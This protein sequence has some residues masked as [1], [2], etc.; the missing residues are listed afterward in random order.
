MARQVRFHETGGPEVLRIDE[1]EVRDPGPGEVRL[2]Q[3][4][5]GVNF[6]DIYSRSGLYPASLP[7]APG[8]E[9][10]GVVEAIGPGV[11]GWAEGDRA[12]YAALSGSYATHRLASAA[13]LIKLPD[14]V[15]D[16]TAAAVTLRGL[17]A[18]FLLHAVHPVRAGDVILLHAAAGGV[19]LILSQWAKALGAEVIGTVSTEAKA[20]IA[21]A[22]GCAHLIV[23]RDA[24]IP[25]RVREITG[26]RMVGVVYDAVGR[27]TFARS[28]DSLAK[29][30]HF[31]SFGQASGAIPPV[32]IQ[33]FG[34]R[35]SLTLTRPMLGDYIGDPEERAR[36]ANDLFTR[37]ARG[38]IKVRVE[39]IYSMERVS[40]AHAE[41]EA[42]RTSGSVVLDLRGG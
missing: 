32:T 24:D 17:T 8:R 20:E 2:R 37:I 31:V 34:N 36:M 27:D 30:G 25:A 1:V 9:G 10:V 11:T 33:D 4:A 14:T 5:S 16:M 35:G 19:G 6:T 42:G 23:G 3:T 41:L 26:G 7:G 28:L 40:E 15:D 39:H 38:D 22:H 18:Q 13:A 29:R 21:R 12:C